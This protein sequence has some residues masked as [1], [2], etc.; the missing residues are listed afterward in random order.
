MAL[1]SL[2]A[3]IR[4]QNQEMHNRRYIDDM[5]ADAQALIRSEGGSKNSAPG[6]TG[7]M[8]RNLTTESGVTDTGHGYRAGLGD[9]GLVGHED[10]S[11]PT[12]TIAQFLKD[13]P[14]FRLGRDEGTNQKL[15]QD[16][17]SSKAAGGGSSGLDISKQ[18]DKTKAW[19]SL[20][21]AG[22]TMLQR[23]REGGLYGGDSEGVGAHMSAYFFQQEG[24][25]DS[26]ARGAGGANIHPD[27]FLARAMATWEAEALPQIIASL[28]SKLGAG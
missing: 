5:V 2:A 25:L 20:S 1:E 9:R 13:Y 14:E 4:A 15:K 23:G 3:R 19:A 28:M 11:A 7:T 10:H 27:P 6:G 24:S 18:F 21:E 12:G 16:R 26:W 17:Q 8:I 22:K